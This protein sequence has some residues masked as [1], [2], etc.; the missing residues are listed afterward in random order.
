[1]IDGAAPVVNLPNNGRTGN[2][3]AVPTRKPYFKD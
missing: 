2:G 1:M 3:V